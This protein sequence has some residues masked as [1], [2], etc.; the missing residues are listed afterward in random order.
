MRRRHR[1]ALACCV[2]GHKGSEAAAHRG[3]VSE[4]PSDIAHTPPGIAHTTAYRLPQVVNCEARNKLVAD[5]YLEKAPGRSAIAFCVDTKH[6]RDLCEVMVGEGI[7][8]EVLTAK[9]YDR[10]GVLRRFQEGATKVV[11]SV[12][13]LLEGTDLP[14][15]TALL[16]CRCETPEGIGGRRRF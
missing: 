12:G 10:E 6:A 11:V 1:S 15:I 2:K 3:R 9:T 5:A 16:M 4:H 14:C 8:A 7:V 13:V